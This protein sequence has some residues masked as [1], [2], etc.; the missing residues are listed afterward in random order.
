MTDVKVAPVGADGAV[1]PLGVTGEPVT[2]VSCGGCGR[3][4]AQPPDAARPWRYCDA[5][6]AREA[7]ARR[8]RGRDHPGLTGQVAWAWEMV[9]RLDQVAERLACSLDGE[10]SVAGVEARIA[11][12]RA[13]AHAELAVAQRERDA[14]QRQA[15]SAWRE[16]AAARGR[17]DAAVHDA[18]G[19]RAD[20]EQARADRDAS[21]AEARDARDAAEHAV[22]ARLAA[23]D[24]RAQVVAREGDLLAALENARAELVTL[25]ARLARS[26]TTAEGRRVE[27][28]A[29][30]RT[31]DD[32]R[33]AVA[34]L[35]TE[36]DAARAEADR[37]RR[38]VDALTRPAPGPRPDVEEEPPTGLHSVNGLR[39]PH[40]G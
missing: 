28:A 19:A 23:E 21:R 26:D 39:L 2:V 29:A 22:A 24:E 35:T 12:T 40:A 34:A 15:A 27:A 20:A 3:P 37:A 6:C 1:L 10:L 38:S 9:E 32:L 16:A 4:V 25:H 31:A 17:A 14:S 11:A 18:A 7:R 8:D 13:E 33:T 5:E 30:L 36:R